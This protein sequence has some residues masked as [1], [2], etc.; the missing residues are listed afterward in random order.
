VFNFFSHIPEIDPTAVHKALSQG[1]ATL[2][3]VRSEAEYA[4]EHAVGSCN[5]PLTKLHAELESL[6]TMQQ[7]LYFICRSG[8]RSATASKFARENGIPAMNVSGGMIAWNE[9][10]LPIV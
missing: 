7:P 6:T 2:V 10:G 3:D 4:D 9:A 5:I 1:K 8:N